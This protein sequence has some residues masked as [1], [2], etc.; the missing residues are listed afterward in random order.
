M[1]RIKSKHKLVLI[2]DDEKG[3]RESV[4]MILRGEGYDVLEAQDGDHALELAKKHHPDLMLLDVKMPGKTG[5]A[6]LGEVAKWPDSQ[7][8]PAVVVISAVASISS[9]VKA[10]KS[11]AYDFL[12]KPLS[13]EKLL[14]TVTNA[15]KNSAI[16]Q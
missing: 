5:L 10:V 15:I 12:E 14:I 8:V 11:G 9:A 13:K 2:A 4:S 6:V 7:A 16:R 1:G 3:I